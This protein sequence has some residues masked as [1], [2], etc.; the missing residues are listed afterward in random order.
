MSQRASAETLISGSARVHWLEPRQQCAAE[1]LQQPAVGPQR[2][3]GVPERIEC[4]LRFAE[5]VPPK[6]DRLVVNSKLL[7][8]SGKRAVIP[9]TDC[10]IHFDPAA[11]QALK[12]LEYD[13][14]K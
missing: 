2:L 9:S 8:G 10:A 14:F 6:V 5:V 12:E 3:R 11:G 7:Q 1:P 13:P 4:P